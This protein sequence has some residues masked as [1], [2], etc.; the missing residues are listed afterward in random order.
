MTATLPLLGTTLT[1]DV[2]LDP[3]GNITG[4]IITGASGLDQTVQE[5]AKVKF[6]TADGTTS[7]SVK[8]KGAALSMSAKAGARTS[9]M[10]VP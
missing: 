9:R 8:A 5:P 2:A 1:V 7:V 4:V 3:T 6:E 10:D